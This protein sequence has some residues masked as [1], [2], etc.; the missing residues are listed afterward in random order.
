M[1]VQKGDPRPH[2]GTHNADDRKTLS[3]KATLWLGTSV[4]LAASSCPDGGQAAGRPVR[5]EPDH[6]VQLIWI[7]YERSQLESPLLIS[8]F[9]GRSL[10][11]PPSH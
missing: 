10:A 6:R 2:S 7:V 11:Q 8:C 3:D 4:R 5:P 1:V 9:E